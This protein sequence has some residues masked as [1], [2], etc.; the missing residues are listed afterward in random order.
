MQ[1]NRNSTVNENNLSG[2]SMQCH[3]NF[4]LDDINIM[5]F[6][7]IIKY[8]AAAKKNISLISTYIVKLV[9]TVPKYF[10]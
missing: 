1:D 10:F 9:K 7:M 6:S 2:T 3:P 4:E 8:N 5:I